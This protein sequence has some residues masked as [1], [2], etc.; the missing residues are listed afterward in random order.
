MIV[1]VLA[2][3]V[4]A[5]IMCMGIP[6]LY[7]GLRV[8]KIE[9]EPAGTHDNM[10]WEGILDKEDEVQSYSWPNQTVIHAD[11]YSGHS[12]T[13]TLD[14]DT[15]E[16]ISVRDSNSSYGGSGDLG[17]LVF[18]IPG[19]ILTSPLILTSWLIH[20]AIKWISGKELQYLILWHKLKGQL[21]TEVAN[22][23]DIA[24]SKQW[25]QQS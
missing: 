24:L 19:I 11:Y 3:Q 2:C 22:E 18:G 25:K 4:L 12:L 8:W 9:D 14:R 23:L 20:M 5:P 6:K 17:V 13:I 15:H 1:A 10:D 7:R 16:L 21:P